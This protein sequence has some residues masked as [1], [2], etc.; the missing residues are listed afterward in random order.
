[1]N[2]GEM[3][4][5]GT[6]IQKERE[7]ERKRQRKERKVE[8]KR[9]SEEEFE[10]EREGRENSVCVRERENN[11]DIPP[12]TYNQIMFPDKKPRKYVLARVA[13]HFY[14]YLKF[15]TNIFTIFFL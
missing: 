10:I 2:R 3:E 1:M 11:F 13:M 5:E 14:L 15:L 9:E 12:S 7:T 6:E 4:R 8:T